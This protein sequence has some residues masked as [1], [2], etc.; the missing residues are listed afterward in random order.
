MT[1]EKRIDQSG[2]NRR[3]VRHSAR[4]VYLSV[5]SLVTFLAIWQ[6]VCWVID[7]PT[8]VLP[9]PY[10][11][12][13]TLFRDANLLAT[14]LAAT[15]SATASGL[16]LAV[17]TGLLVAMLMRASPTLGQLIYS[18]IVLSQAVPL[19]AIAPVILIWFGLGLAAKMIIVAAVCFFPIAVNTHEAFRTVSK[20]YVNYLTTLD[21]SR[22]Q[23][24]RHLLIPA[25]LPGIFAGAKIAATYCVLGAVV[26]EWLGGVRGIGIYMTR[27]LQSFRTDKLF[28]AIF[29]VMVIS[30]AIF[31]CVSWI[32]NRLTPWVQRR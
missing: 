18:H 30:Y 20:D 13:Q 28:A 19:I 7:A 15:I 8:Y 21:A 23:R 17:I 11:T 32:G 5:L 1:P 29:V 12:L 24:Y 27:A 10:V 9:S 31:Q 16:A 25:T 4:S 6:L 3:S 14:H 26:G 2:K 22:W